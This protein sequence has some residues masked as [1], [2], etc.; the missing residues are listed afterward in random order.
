MF[1]SLLTHKKSVKWSHAFVIG[2]LPHSYYWLHT[3]QGAIESVRRL[4]GTH[5]TFASWR[6]LGRRK[7]DRQLSSTSF[8]TND[9][10]YCKILSIVYCRTEYVFFS[11]LFNVILGKTGFDL[12]LL[13]SPLNTLPEN[14]YPWILSEIKFVRVSVID[15]FI[16]FNPRKITLVWSGNIEKN[17]LKC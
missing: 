7:V 16:W 4:Q 5:Q 1:I 12:T 8:Y 10:S 15:N 11:S 14:I 13:C 3:T 9:P 2:I 6:K 17:C